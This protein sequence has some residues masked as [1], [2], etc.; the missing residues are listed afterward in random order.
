MYPCSTKTGEILGNPSPRAER[1]PETQ[2][3]SH[4]RRLGKSRGLREI[5]RDFPRLWVLLPPCK[6]GIDPCP[7]CGEWITE[8]YP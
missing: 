5:L 4:G 3:I 6:W 7:L 8:S 2:E 1:F